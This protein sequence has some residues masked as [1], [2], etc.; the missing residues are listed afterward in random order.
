V[1]SYPEAVVRVTTAALALALLLAAPASSRLE[2]APTYY[3]RVTGGSMTIETRE[4][5]GENTGLERLTWTVAPHARGTR[6]APGFPTADGSGGL[7]SF[8]LRFPVRGTYSYDYDEEDSGTCRETFALTPA[9]RGTLAA[10]QVGSRVRFTWG[11][12]PRRRAGYVAHECRPP[13]NN[14]LLYFAANQPATTVTLAA[15][16]LVKPTFTITARGRH[17]NEG[18][19]LNWALALN[20][21]RLGH[22]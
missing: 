3:Y 20:V 22:R 17:T 10:R 19:T 2:K 11:L 14:A 6:P 15:G 1:R 9:S 13:T 16:A 5:E 18:K 7:R 21:R 12:N 8:Q 4:T